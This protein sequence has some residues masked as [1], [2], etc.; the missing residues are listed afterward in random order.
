MP[1]LNGMS[2]MIDHQRDVLVRHASTIR[3]ATVISVERDERG[4]WVRSRTAGHLI[5]EQRCSTE[6]RAREHFE[7][8]VEEHYEQTQ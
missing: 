6:T 3:P 1:G 5:Y 4:Y 7:R 2:K 8:R